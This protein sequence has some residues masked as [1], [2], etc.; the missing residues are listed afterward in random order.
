LFS[1]D[2][3]LLFLEFFKANRAVL[4]IITS[5]QYFRALKQGPLIKS[6]NLN[7][8]RIAVS[9]A[10]APLFSNSYI[11]WGLK[12]VFLVCMAFLDFLELKHVCFYGVERLLVVDR[13][14]LEGLAAAPHLEQNYVFFS[15]LDR[16]AS[17]N[18]YF[19]N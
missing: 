7:P 18:P 4:L 9:K 12:L 8:I 15:I 1:F 19:F 17:Q 14:K 5:E 11:S 2:G 10:F 13:V 6:I 16:M 3:D